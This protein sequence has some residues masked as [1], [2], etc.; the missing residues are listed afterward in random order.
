MPMPS[1]GLS[2]LVC[3]PQ[4][5]WGGVGGKVMSLSRS[6]RSWKLGQLVREAWRFVSALCCR[7][8]RRV[9]YGR[10]MVVPCGRERAG[11]CTIPENSCGGIAFLFPRGA[12]SGFEDDSD[13]EGRA[14]RRPVSRRMRRAR[15]RLRV[16]LRRVIPTPLVLTYP[17]MI[18][19]G[20]EINL[21]G[22]PPVLAR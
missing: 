18:G 1:R 13:A 7:I 12:A 17:Q 4:R 21:P 16:G 8:S 3:V 2:G 15:A 10:D 6:L 19:S 11:T 9:M 22:N 14:T 20:G 5:R